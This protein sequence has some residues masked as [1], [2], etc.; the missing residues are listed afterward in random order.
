E[1][2]SRKI[3]IEDLP[4]ESL[5]FASGFQ[6]SSLYLQCKRMSDVVLSAALLIIFSPV[7]ALIAALIKLESSGPVIF[8]QDRV[9][10]LGESFTVFKFRSMRRDAEEQTGP[11]WAKEND[12][13]VTRVGALLRKCR[14][15]ELPQAFN[16]FRGEMSFIGPRPERP[17]FVELLN[18]NF[19]YY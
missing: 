10:Y 3:W 17:Y 8:R 4:A 6:P 7:M 1:K 14:L 2:A 11:T 19:P 9:G 16:V 15:D 18:S 12:E 13:R 5:I